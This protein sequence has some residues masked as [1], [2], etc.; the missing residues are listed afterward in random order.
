MK[1]ASAMMW[2]IAN[3][4]AND[5]VDDK[6][7]YEK[8]KQFLLYEIMISWFFGKYCKV[9]EMEGP[10]KGKVVFSLASMKHKMRFLTH[11]LS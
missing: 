9:G 4:F 6:D 5:Y 3:I 1:F 11:Y 8:E 10:A 2:V 7:N